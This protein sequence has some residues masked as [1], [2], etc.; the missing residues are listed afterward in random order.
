MKALLFA[1]CL[2]LAVLPMC[3]PDASKTTTDAAVAK[4]ASPAELRAQ[5]DILRDSATA[6]WQRMMASDDQKLRDLHALLGD[7]RQV[8]TLDKP[9]LATLRRAAD[10]LPRQRYDRQTMASSALIDRYDAV[11]DSVLKVV[12][13]LAAPDGNAP[14]AAVR[15][16]VEAIQAADGNVVAYRAHYD[17]A[18]KAYNAYLQAHG[19]ELA[20]LGGQYASLQPLPLFELGR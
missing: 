7:L 13:P 18:A 10:R 3:K 11:Q 2:T 12:Y 14:T 6:N 16:Y 4:P 19:P 15:N 8:P 20:K 9:Q 1:S 5:F 17:V